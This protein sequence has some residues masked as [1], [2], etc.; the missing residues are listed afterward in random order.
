MSLLVVPRVGV[1][2]SFRERLGNF[3][4]F[5]MGE[6]KKAIEGKKWV[7]KTADQIIC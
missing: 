1:F 3:N 2:K 6:T 7:Y 5:G 4:I